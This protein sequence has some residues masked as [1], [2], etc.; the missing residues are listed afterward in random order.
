MSKESR[1]L[2]FLDGIGHS[3]VMVCLRVVQYIKYCV[4]Q[5]G[6]VDATFESSHL[7]VNLFF[8]LLAKRVILYVARV[9]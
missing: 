9:C 8:K 3:S 2:L 5:Y 6:K 1:R 4:R 7:A